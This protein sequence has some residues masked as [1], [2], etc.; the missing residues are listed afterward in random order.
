MKKVV[1]AGYARSPF[2]S[3]TRASWRGCAP[4]IWPRRWSAGWSA[5]PASRRRHRGHHPRLRLSRGRAGPQRRAPDRPARRTCRSSVG[6][7]TVNRFCGSSMSAI[8]I[9]P[10]QIAIGA[11][12][13]FICAGVEIMSRVPMMGFNPLPNPELATKQPGAYI[14]MGDTA[15][16]VAD[17]VPDHPRRAG[18]VRGRQPAEGAPPPRDGR[19]AQPTRSCRSRPRRARSATDGCIRPDTTAEALAGAEARLRRQR[20]RSPPAPPRR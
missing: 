13:A 7:M 8:H 2:T 9:A 11:G 12:E 18:G 20:H 17:Q 6:G 19:Q 4:T 14:G 1:I 10:G 16:N 15:E 5:G 3:P